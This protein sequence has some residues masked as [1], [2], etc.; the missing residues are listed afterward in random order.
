VDERIHKFL[1][2]AGI[3][4]RRAAED[5][6][7]AGRVRVNGSIVDVPGTTIDPRRDRVEVDG[8]LVVPPIAHVY[9]ALH[10][11]R[12]VVSTVTDPHR[13]R[14][15]VDLVDLRRRLYPVGRLDYDS[16]G[17]L[18]LTDDGDLTMRLTHP[19]HAVQKEYQVLVEGGLNA[20]QIER[21][22]H[23][24]VLDGRLSAPAEVDITKT[25]RKPNWLR[26]VVREGRNRQIRR[27]I[28]AVG[29]RVVRLIRTRV[30]PV[31]LGE[32]PVGQWRLLSQDEVAK[33]QEAAR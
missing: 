18:L 13:R 33:L 27:M 5:L 7:R 6:V 29:G 32:L 24:V 8:T 1:A 9:V 21:L 16:E 28:E 12:G 25:D 19:R 10:K 17:L 20:R 14:T 30:G 26:I 3:A 4:S 11:P 31:V 22:R 15:V 23:G 2:H